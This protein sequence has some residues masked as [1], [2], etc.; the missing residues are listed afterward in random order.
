M[1]APFERQR[2][3]N[4]SEYDVFKIVEEEI[5]SLRKG[6]RVFAH[7]SLGEILSSP[8]DPAYHSINSK[9]VDILVVDWAGWPVAAVEYQGA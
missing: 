1:D 2:L 3:L 9:R 4:W 5:R 7:T 6:H 8:N